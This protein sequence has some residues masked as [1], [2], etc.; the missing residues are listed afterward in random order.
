MY[1][2]FLNYNIGEGGAKWPCRAKRTPAC[3]RKIKTR[4]KIF[5]FTTRNK[6]KTV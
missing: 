4:K 5:C 2:Y 6:Y 3:S 1:L